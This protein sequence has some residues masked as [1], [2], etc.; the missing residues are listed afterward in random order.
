MKTRHSPSPSPQPRQHQES[1]LTTPL[2]TQIVPT[3]AAVPTADDVK[4]KPI[5][6]SPAP[7]NAASAKKETI[8]A[9]EVP[10]PSVPAPAALPAAVKAK[11]AV[12][13][14]ALTTAVDKKEALKAAPK[15]K[16]RPVD[17]PADENVAK[18]QCLHRRLHHEE[19]AG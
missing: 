19:K 12:P 9:V 17:K 1:R 4:K 6:P 11:P 18:D 15:T 5:V 14:T 7:V 10:K 8:E 2:G 3:A 13:V 16:K